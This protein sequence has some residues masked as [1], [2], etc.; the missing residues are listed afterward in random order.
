MKKK[1]LTLVYLAINI[2]IIIII[3][4]FEDVYKRQG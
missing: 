3:G 2:A 4:A 1:Y